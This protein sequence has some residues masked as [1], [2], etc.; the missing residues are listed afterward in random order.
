MKLKYYDNHEFIDIENYK[1][2]SFEK[3]KVGW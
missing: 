2:I 1:R 3:F